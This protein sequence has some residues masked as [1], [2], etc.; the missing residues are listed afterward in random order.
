MVSVS[1]PNASVPSQ[2]LYHLPRGL[3]AP[4]P[5]R[6]RHHP[7]GPRALVLVPR[8]HLAVVVQLGQRDVHA[9]V[10]LLQLVKPSLPAVQL[11]L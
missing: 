1:P 3:R 11:Q 2:P 9:L 5:T 7:T 6:T 4:L 10:L 8:P